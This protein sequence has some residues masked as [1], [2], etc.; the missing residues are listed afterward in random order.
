MAG[1]GGGEHGSGRARYAH[2]FSLFI[3]VSNRAGTTSLHPFRL[4][5]EGPALHDTTRGGKT[6]LVTSFQ[7]HTTRGR[8][9]LVHFFRQDT[10][11]GIGPSLIHF[12]TTRHVL[13]LS[14][15]HNGCPAMRRG[16][17]L[18][19]LSFSF[20]MTQRGRFPSSS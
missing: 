5:K 2:H 10:T 7:H 15:Q 8:P 14:I 12:D 16:P 9:L 1:E 11:R 20:E 3:F 13:V 18:L 19:V 17:P 4:D 6:L